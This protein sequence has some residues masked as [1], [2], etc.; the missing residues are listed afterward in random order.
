MQ[1]LH[2]EV[3]SESREK[4]PELGDF[5][6]RKL[7]PREDW[8]KLPEA[9]KKRFS[10][11]LAGGATAIYSGIVKEI[12]STRAGRILA[13]ALRIVGAPLP[14]FDHVDVASVVTVT[15]DVK[16]GGQIWTRIY[17]NRTDFPQVIHSAKR[18]SGPTGL[19]EHVGF[20]VSM[21][22]RVSACPR[23]LTFHSA[24]YRFCGLSLPH[25]LT[26]GQ[27]TVRHL[28]TDASHFVFDMTLRHPIAGELLYQSAE[29]G[30]VA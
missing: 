13:Q 8:E 14:V 5:R 3:R 4:M 23:G 7:L 6:F 20:G 29:Y 26:P 19:E 2:K 28:E 9:V 16:T 18:F 17:A 11:R 10:K 21:M 24:G 22:L 30:D 15:E 1:L 12:R 27:L 25:W